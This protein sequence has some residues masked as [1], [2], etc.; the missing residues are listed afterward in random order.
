MRADDVTSTLDLALAAS[1]RLRSRRLSSTKTSSVTKKRCT[2][3]RLRAPTS[4]AQQ[5]SSSGVT[6]SC[7]RP[8]DIGACS[9]GSS[10][11][12]IERQPR[13]KPRD[14]NPLFVPNI[15]RNRVAIFDFLILKIIKEPEATGKIE[16]VM[17]LC[18]KNPRRVRCGSLLQSIMRIRNNYQ[19]NDIYGSS[20][21]PK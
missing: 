12:T 20:I 5:P 11:L 14:S 18:G 10:P 16:M 4:A 3:W 9:T 2:T 8:A 15:L 17:L 19:Q 21:D 7:Y 13:P 6:G 1:L